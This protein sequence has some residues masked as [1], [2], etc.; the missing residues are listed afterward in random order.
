MYTMYTISDVID[1][2]GDILRRKILKNIQGIS[3]L[4]LE[5]TSASNVVIS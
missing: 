5:I 1:M 2:T 4:I 3:I